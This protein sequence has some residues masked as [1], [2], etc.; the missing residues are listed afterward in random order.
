MSSSAAAT[1]MTRPARRGQIVDEPLVHFPR[2][3]RQFRV[4]DERLRRRVVQDEHDLRE[5]PVA[6]SEI[7]D[8]AA[9]KQ[10][11]YASRNLP[12]LVQFLAWKTS[13]MADGAA[14]PIEERVA[15]KARE[16]VRGQAPAGG[17]QERHASIL[18]F[19]A[20]L[21]LTPSAPPR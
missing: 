11:P 1:K 7:D 14:Q 5:E 17:R 19:L 2:G 9:A 18:S 20:R 8:A 16:V 4:D 3:G 21:R 10:P 12:R 15:G 13:R 6:G